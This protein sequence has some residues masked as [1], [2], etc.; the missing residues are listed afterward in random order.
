VP[1]REN[2]FA[3]QAKQREKNVARENQ[4][5]IDEQLSRLEED[6]RRLKIEFDVYFGGGSKRLPYDTK[7]RVETVI[8]RIAD[9]RSLTFAQRFQYN[10]LVARYTSF[11]EMWRRTVQEREEGRSAA[12][13]ARSAHRIEPSAERRASSASFVCHDARADVPVI[14]Q[15]YD[16]LIEAKRACGEPT[17]EISFPRFHH[18]I[19]A[20]TDSLKER[21]GCAG[22]RFF[23]EVDNGRVVFK[24][25]AED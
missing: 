14:K 1:I 10:S 19:A 7:G 23:V 11:R 13:L 18:M 22:V 15:L 25:R 3:R 16:K 4:V 21:T 6:I 24:A 9:D 8:K 5:S 12:D 20:Q 17:A 2:K